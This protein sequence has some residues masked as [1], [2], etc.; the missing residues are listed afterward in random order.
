MGSPFKRFYNRTIAIVLES[1]I[2]YPV[3]LTAEV[4]LVLNEDKIAMVVDLLPTVVLAAGIA[5]ALIVVRAH[6]GKK[7]SNDW[8][9]MAAA[10]I[11]DIQF[12]N[13]SPQ[14]ASGEE[15]GH[16]IQIG[17]AEEP[18]QRNENVKLGMLS[19]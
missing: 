13:L 4:A 3:L 12:G 6:Y 19:V 14:I 17:G 9:S 10:H 7:S 15:G 5:P 11:S 1:G 8:E 18:E 2:L 16:D